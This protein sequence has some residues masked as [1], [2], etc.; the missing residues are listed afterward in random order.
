MK[1]QQNLNASHRRQPTQPQHLHSFHLRCRNNIAGRWQFFGRQQQS[2]SRSATNMKLIDIL[3][4]KEPSIPGVLE[5]TGPTYEME[6]RNESG[7]KINQPFQSF[8]LCV[9][10]VASWQELI[11]YHRQPD[12]YQH[13]LSMFWSFMQNRK[14]VWI[15]DQLLVTSERISPR[16]FDLIKI[17]SVRNNRSTWC[18]LY[19]HVR[20]DVMAEAVQT[21]MA[22]PP[23]NV[24]TLSGKV[25]RACGSSIICLPRDATLDWIIQTN[26]EYAQIIISE[27][28]RQS[29]LQSADQCSWLT[30]H[31]RNLE[32][33]NCHFDADTVESFCESLGQSSCIMKKLN[34]LLGC[35]Q[36]R[37][38]STKHVLQSF[39]SLFNQQTPCSLAVLKIGLQKV[40]IPANEAFLDAFFDALANYQGNI[41]Q[42]ELTEGK[43][44]IPWSSLIG[45]CEMLMTSSTITEL[46]FFFPHQSFSFDHVVEASQRLL[47]ALHNNKNIETLEF[48]KGEK[49]PFPKFHNVFDRICGYRRVTKKLTKLSFSMEP[50][51]V[52]MDGN[53]DVDST[54]A[55]T[56]RYNKLAMKLLLDEARISDN[57]SVLYEAISFHSNTFIEMWKCGGPE[58]IRQKNLLLMEQK[59][60]EWIRSMDGRHSNKCCCVQ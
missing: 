24:T 56:I 42:F 7:S 2:S 27:S 49:K 32:L 3:Q 12:E 57:P 23:T 47:P 30:S 21:N 22:A 40:Q 48:S 59:R 26:E 43:S 5:Q 25:L 45:W 39:T 51:L 15:G 9:D 10:D 60:D 46:K 11:D 44:E 55:V 19:L 54:D 37:I 50:P 20:E 52:V 16:G 34:I 53:E 8:I 38:Q 33:R 36:H 29:V 6:I 28:Y 35:S 1:M 14:C 41:Q 58:R 31:A 18:V 17:F 4:S 13:R